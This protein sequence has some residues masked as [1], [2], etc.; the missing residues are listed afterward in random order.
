[1][2]KTPTITATTPTTQ[3]KPRKRATIIVKRQYAGNLDMEKAFTEVLTRALYKIPMPQSKPK[4]P[5]LPKTPA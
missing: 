1:M 3:T 2:T 5:C 4:E